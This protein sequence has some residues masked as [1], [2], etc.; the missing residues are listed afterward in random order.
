[1]KSFEKISKYK[2]LE[3]E[4]E[5]FQKENAKTVP[6]VVGALGVINKSTENYLKVLPTQ[7]SIEE[8]QKPALLV[9]A[10]SMLKIISNN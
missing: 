8:I 1:M 10:T 9:T 4:I 2:D 7:I 3:I 6:I 5:R